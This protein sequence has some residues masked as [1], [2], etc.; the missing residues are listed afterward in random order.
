MD[1]ES[2]SATASTVG[3]NPHS[4]S[5]QKEVETQPQPKPVANPN[6]EFPDGGLQAWLQVLGGWVVLAANWGLVNTFGVYQTYYQTE[7][8]SSYSA[9]SISWIGSLQA[10]LLF[11]AGLAAGPLFDGGYFKATLTTGLFMIVFGMFMTSISK[12]YWQVLLAQGICIGIGMGLT[13]LPAAAIQA[14]YFLKRRAF[15]VGIAGTGSPVGGIIFPIIFSKLHPQVGFGWATRVIAFILLGLSVIP[16]VFMRPRLPPPPRV[17]SIVDNT[18]WK[19]ISFMTFTVGAML[20]FL[21]LYTAF[22]Y[23]QLFDEL[24]HLSSK[25]FAPYMVTLLNVGS[26]V[27]RLAPMYVGDKLG[28][29]NMTILCT[30]A[31]ALLA[32]GWMGIDSLGGIAVFTI[33]YGITSGAVVVGAPVV[34][35]KLSPDM[36]R[37]GTRLGM[38]FT[39]SA[40]TVLVGTPIAGAILGDFSR[41]RWLATIGYSAGGLVLGGVI[42]MGTWVSVFKQRGTWKI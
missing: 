5:E 37:M 6:D 3:R 28:V 23:I 39:F 33:L 32:F 12:T 7:M 25:N 22:F 24:N 31:S 8:L 38:A 13:F 34:I 10:C 40:V 29:L 35:M 17:R 16:I 14:Q 36:A 27:G 21:V 15:A 18:A 9:S 42:M 4:D 19:D 30:L 11:L 1:E 26:V 20:V 2:N 41:T